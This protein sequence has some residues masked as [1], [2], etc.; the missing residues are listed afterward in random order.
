MYAT[1]SIVAPARKKKAAG[2]QKSHRSIAH[3]SCNN[4]P[5]FKDAGLVASLKK[6]QTN[7]KLP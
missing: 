6:T 4:T 3:L 2:L 1:Y 5:G 7:Y